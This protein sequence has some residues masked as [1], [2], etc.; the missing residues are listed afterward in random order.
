MNNKVRIGKFKQ[1]ISKFYKWPHQ[2]GSSAKLLVLKKTQQIDNTIREV[3]E[4][5]DIRLILIQYF[6]HS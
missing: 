1:L 6:L 2:S 3:L 4:R 5:K